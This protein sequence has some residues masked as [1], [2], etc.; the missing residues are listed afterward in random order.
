[1]NLLSKFSALWVPSARGN[2]KLYDIINGND[3]SVVRSSVKQITNQ[4]GL[5]EEIASNV[6]PSSFGTGGWGALVEGARTNLATR[7]NEFET[8]D[9]SNGVTDSGTQTSIFQ[10]R[11]ARLVTPSDT[12]G[13]RYLRKNVGNWNGQV[14]TLSAIIEHSSSNVF[15]IMSRSGTSTTTRATYNFTNDS[16]VIEANTAL[17]TISSSQI[18]QLGTG[19]NGGKI[20]RFE[21][22]VT[23]TSTEQLR[24]QLYPG[25]FDAPILGVGTIFHHFQTEIGSFASSPIVTE[26][27]TFT[28]NADVITKTGASDLIGQTEGTLFAV[29]DTRVLGDIFGGGASR[30]IFAVSDNT[31]SNRIRIVKSA[32]DRFI[33]N[34]NSGGVSQATFQTDTNQAGLFKILVTYKENDF[35]FYVNGSL[36]NQDTSGVV[37]A[38]DRIFVGK[39]ESADPNLANFFDRILLAGIGKTA[40][41]EAEA[42][43][44]TTL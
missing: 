39:I 21:I 26:G 22:T 40:I 11:G 9:F 24:V 29:V 8:Y 28:R 27:A 18:T 34:I 43:A 44:L 14:T 16:V 23:N 30:Y 12:G 19:P 20:V 3:A 1:M 33:I 4:N 42:I 15:T 32:A 31:S 6:T 17:T 10:G 25:G 41:T 37:P 35:R 2:G 5:L 36:V 13:N 7:S 38:C